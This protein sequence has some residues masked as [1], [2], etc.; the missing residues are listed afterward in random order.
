MPCNTH[1]NVFVLSFD[2]YLVLFHLS[3]VYCRHCWYFD[4]PI[5]ISAT[6]KLKCNSVTVTSIK[7]VILVQVRN[8]AIA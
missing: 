4:M 2:L 7:T 3:A 5:K 8:N 6:S 1:C